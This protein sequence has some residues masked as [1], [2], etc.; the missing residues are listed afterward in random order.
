MNHRAAGTVFAGNIAGGFALP[1]FIIVQNRTVK[2]WRKTKMSTR[3][4]GRE[5]SRN[6]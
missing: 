4:T 3:D 6:T 2:K 5:S 1:R